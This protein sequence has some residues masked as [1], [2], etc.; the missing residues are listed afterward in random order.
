[1]DLGKVGEGGFSTDEASVEATGGGQKETEP[2]WAEG[3]ARST[4]V[5]EVVSGQ[6][7]KTTIKGAEQGG[8]SIE[9]RGGGQETQGVGPEVKNY[10]DY[11]WGLGMRMLVG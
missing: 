11:L 4:M 3:H 8:K 7:H 1:L 9:K 6:T 10:H 5:K 2:L